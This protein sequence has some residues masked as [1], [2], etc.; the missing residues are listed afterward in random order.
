MHPEALSK[1]GL[2]IPDHEKIIPRAV[3]E[4][5]KKVSSQLM[6]GK[7]ADVSKNP[8]PSFIIHPTT[9][10][11]SL[12]NDLSFCQ[13]T[14][15]RAAKCTDPLGRMKLIAT[16]YVSMWWMNPSIIQ[17]RVPINPII[18]ETY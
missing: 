9:N 6:K 17:Q 18:G 2:N 3:K 1:G 5:L 11:I 10:Q 13:T 7:L 12:K 14:L 4:V 16:W 15:K 8:S